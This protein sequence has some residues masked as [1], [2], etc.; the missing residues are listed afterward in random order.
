MLDGMKMAA[1]GMMA[2]MA[3][4]DVIANNLANVGTA[5]FRKDSLSVSSFSQVLN[6]QV[7]MFGPEEPGYMQAGGNFNATGGLV[8]NNATSF[9]QGS[10]KETGNSMDLALDD[11]G[12]GFFCVQGADGVQFTRNGAFRLNAAGYLVSQDGSYL[13]GQRGPIQVKGTSFVVTADGKVK[14]DGNVIDQILVATFD[15]QANLA[16]QGDSNF[17]AAAGGRIST[18]FQMKQGYLE[19]SNVNAIQEMVN[20]MS[21]MQAYEAGQKLL[22]SQDRIMGKAAEL[23]RLR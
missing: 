14:V 3:Q 6:R 11:N 1:Q 13:L 4:Q 8:Y 18:D 21:V 10:L 16:K 17:L 12:K 15:D 19:M 2:M 7:G 23:G 22:Q 5:G 9:A 20:M